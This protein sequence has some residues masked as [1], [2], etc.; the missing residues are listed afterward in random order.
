MEILASSL[1]EMIDSTHLQE[2]VP[3][4]LWY[5]ISVVGIGALT[6]IFNRLVNFLI[7]NITELKE[8]HAE[9]S[10]AIEVM[11]EVLRGIQR[12]LTDHD[13]DIRELRGIGKKT[14]GQ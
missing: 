4:Y 5:A 10:K 12:I 8:G 2:S 1:S 3:P 13:A 7:A 9:N 6:Y 11:Q 14:R